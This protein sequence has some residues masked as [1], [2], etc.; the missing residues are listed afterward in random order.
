MTT[1][2]FSQY[3]LNNKVQSPTAPIDEAAA[4]GVAQLKPHLK[5]CWCIPPKHN[6]EF[7]AKMED[8]LAVYTP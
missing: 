6:A 1:H 3:I 4:K 8:V 7:V 5:A 2:G